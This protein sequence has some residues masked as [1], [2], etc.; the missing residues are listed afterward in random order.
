[1]MGHGMTGHGLA[2][3]L[4]S[5][6]VAF[7]DFDGTLIR[8]DSLPL[9]IAEVI[10]RHR[11]RL[12]FADAL[13]SATHR[14]LRGRPLGADFRG[15]VKAIVLKRTL[16]GVPLAVAEAAAERLAQRLRW[17]GPMVEAL[18]AH[19][20]A[21]RTVVVATG[22]LNVYMPALLRHLPVDHLMAT[23]MEVAD[24]HLTGR[25]V[26]G[27]CVRGHKA[28]RVQAWLAQHGPFPRTWGYGNHPSDRPM[29]ALLDEPA[30][31]R[32]R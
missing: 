3:P 31:I 30:V 12:A 10:G 21:G 14:H 22:A 13:R 17:H 23:E 15:T 11:T 6:G 4:T 16:R 28:D 2:G 5:Q 1:M 25:I 24:G 29:L 9:F 18:H 27:N 32:I 7:F 20:D 26:S 19:R 8:G